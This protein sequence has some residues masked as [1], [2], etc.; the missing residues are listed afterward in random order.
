M[1]KLIIKREKETRKEYLF[2]VAIAYLEQLDNYTEAL[3]ETII[4]DDAECDGSC[5][6]EDMKE[7]L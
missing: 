6:V 3:S 1:K 2:R 4:Y 7:E 5:L